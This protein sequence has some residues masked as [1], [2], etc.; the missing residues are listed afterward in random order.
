M[1][2]FKSTRKLILFNEKCL[3]KYCNNNNITDIIK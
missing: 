2:F 1:F 3:Y